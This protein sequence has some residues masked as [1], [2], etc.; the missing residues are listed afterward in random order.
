MLLFSSRQ[1]HPPAEGSYLALPRATL[2]QRHAQAQSEALLPD[3][4]PVAPPPE[5]AAAA[6]GPR[7]SWRHGAGS[8]ER[9]KIRRQAPTP[10]DTTARAEE[11][12]SGGPTLPATAENKGVHNHERGEAGPIGQAG[13]NTAAAATW[14]DT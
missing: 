2:R 13:S 1:C 9:R 6:I 4:V 3:E 14:T 11:P 10:T 12:N 5:P 8:E 7:R